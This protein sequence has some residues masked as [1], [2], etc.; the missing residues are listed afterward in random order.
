MPRRSR[1]VQPSLSEVRRTFDS[2]KHCLLAT[3]LA[4]HRDGRLAGEFL[5]MMSTM[6]PFQN[7]IPYANIRTILFPNEKYAKLSEKQSFVKTAEF[8]RKKG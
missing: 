5:A 7:T 3:Q 8:Q 1:A 4:M 2:A 6:C